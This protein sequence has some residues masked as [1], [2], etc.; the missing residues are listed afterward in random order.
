MF[1]LV[2]L[3]VPLVSADKLTYS[4]GE[5][6]NEDL[7]VTISDTIFFGLINLGDIG[8]MELKS[9]KRVDYVKQVRLG[10]KVVMYYDFEFSEDYSNGLG[11][12]EFTN[13]RNG[14][15][16]NKNYK[17]VY[18]GEEEYE[19][20]I[21]TCKN[22]ISLN[23][24]KTNQCSQIGSEIKTRNVW[25]PYNSN[26]IPKGNIR[27]GIEVEVN[28]ND[29]IDGI[30]E[31]GNKLIEKHASW[32]ESLNVD[33]ISY[34]TFDEG[35]GTF[36]NDS[37]SSN[38]FNLF[39]TPAWID[40]ILK[41]GLNISKTAGQFG[42]T[43]GTDFA[44][45]DISDSITISTWINI[46]SVS[47]FRII[48][49]KT[50]NFRMSFTSINEIG[51]FLY[52]ATESSW[53][54]DAYI[55]DTNVWKHV[56][57]T[58]NGTGVNGFAIYINGTLMP[59]HNNVFGG[60]WTDNTNDL[61]LA[62]YETPGDYFDGGLDEIGIWY[63]ALSPAEVTQLYNGGLGLPFE[64]G[65]IILNSPANV[66]NFTINEIDFNVSI[67]IPLLKNVTIEIWDTDNSTLGYNNTNTSG[68]EGNY[69]WNDIPLDDGNYNWSIIAYDTSDVNYSSDLRVFEIAPFF[70]LN[71]T[72]DSSKTE[73][74]TTTFYGQIKSRT[75]TSVYLQYNNTNYS[76]SINSLGDGE[77]I[78]S[79]TVTT[80]SVSAD[81]NVTWFFWVNGVNLTAYNQTVLNVNLDNCSSYTYFIVNYTLVDELT[82]ANINNSNST[83]ESL[84]ILKTIT[85]GEVAQFN[86]S[87]NWINTTASVC[88][89]VNLNSSGLRLWE[90]SRY[91]STDH[92][93]EQHNIQNVSMTSLPNEITLRILPSSSATTF[94]IAYKSASFLPIPNAVIDIQRKYIGEGLHKT[95]ESPLTDTIGETSASLDLN[96]VL[97][98]I[99][100]SKDGITLATF[101]N[102]AVACDNLLTGDCS[103]TLNERSSITLIDN[104]DIINDFNYGLTQDN[105]TITLTF[106]IPSGENSLV[107]LFANQS[108][109]LGNQTSCNQTLFASSGQVQ[110]EIDNTLGDVYVMVDVYSDGVLI[111]R[112]ATTI[113]DDRSQYFGT[114]NIVLTFFLVLSLVL[115]MISS[116]ITVLIGLLIGLIASSLLMF[117]N[118]GDIFGVA[119]VLTYLIII[120]I[121]LIV[122]ISGRER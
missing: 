84:V 49:S 116:P 105:R 64:G 69:Y 1:C 99:I 17:Y 75:L 89:E 112:T 63:R 93:Y 80:P 41:K 44:F 104:Y 10:N 71:Y 91:G 42:N 26:D 43:S 119:P 95:I 14:K 34:W 70:E 98:R 58:Y 62:S 19:S 59:M 45:N 107:N 87:I 30:W 88:S 6:G 85:G 36:A 11:D 18:W 68:I 29:Y 67:A 27:I 5:N 77:Y 38:N 108:T 120:I 96:S 114:D 46:T 37:H 13:M 115:L 2:L 47:G 86:S 103:I 7:K 51:L 110:C 76:A 28:E 65:D 4:D 61:Y 54:T 117:L 53:E 24:T 122:K 22:L 32:T 79:R 25:L 92:V 15:Q 97:Y 94:R 16:V 74:S 48:L 73:V 20:P 82:Q 81:T 12:V 109:I 8:T 100:V 3:A 106:T 121:I 66:S 33:L 90:Q 118:A 60:T 55:T 35:I 50:A 78:L 57:V 31:V 39:N 9:H 102:V 72:Y 56:V 101:E 83:I 113:Y 40:G 21:Y 111:R 23:G 52:G